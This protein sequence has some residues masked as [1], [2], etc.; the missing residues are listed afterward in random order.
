MS[1]HDV[2]LVCLVLLLKPQQFF[3]ANVVRKCL[4]ALRYVILHFGEDFLRNNISNKVAGYS[5]KRNK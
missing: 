1:H 3:S 5:E 2:T 4:V